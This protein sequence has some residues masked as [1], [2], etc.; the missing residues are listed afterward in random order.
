MS[1]HN[2]EIDFGRLRRLRSRHRRMLVLFLVA[3]VTTVVG[4][5]GLLATAES[6]SPVIFF[7]LAHHVGFTLI[8]VGIILSFLFGRQACPRCSKPFYVAEGF[9]RFLCVVNLSNRN[10]VHCGLSLDEARALDDAAAGP[11]DGSDAATPGGKRRSIP[12]E[13]E[14]IS[15]G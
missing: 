11:P 4:V 14:D 5:V 8:G 15:H 6:E 3:M 12:A 13:E 1:D 2:G 7:Q 10:C 9:L